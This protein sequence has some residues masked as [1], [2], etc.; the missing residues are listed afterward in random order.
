MKTLNTLTS[1]TKNFETCVMYA[2]N[3]QFGIEIGSRLEYLSDGYSLPGAVKFISKHVDM[4][5]GT[6]QERQLYIRNIIISKLIELKLAFET[7]EGESFLK[8]NELII[9]K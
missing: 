9:L 5:A 2:W 1:K 6:Q 7:K 4:F 8:T 3:T